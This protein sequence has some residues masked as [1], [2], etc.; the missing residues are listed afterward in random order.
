MEMIA[1]EAYHRQRM[2]SYS[3]KH[4][5]TAAAIRYKTSRKT[6]YKW[7]KRDDGS[8]DSLWD[9]SHRP[10]SHPRQ[11]TP[12]EDA[13]IRRVASRC[14]KQ[15]KLLMYERLLAKGYTR[16]YGGFKRHFSQLGLTP[17]V[18]KRTKRKPKP[19]QR[20][21]YPG[22]KVQIDVKFVPSYCVTDGKKYYQFTAVDECSR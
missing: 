14:N 3:R 1:Q 17:T 10:H 22:Q 9:Q 11:H 6:V 20:A 12:E 15:D 19:Y 8:I 4:G 13:L 7:L 21:E 18:K 16:S 2:I 5:V